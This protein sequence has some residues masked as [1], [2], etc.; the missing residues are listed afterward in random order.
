MIRI[1]IYKDQ[2]LY[3]LFALKYLNNLINIKENKGVLIK[4]INHDIKIN[5]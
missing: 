2:N 4:I 5:L 3:V 1:F